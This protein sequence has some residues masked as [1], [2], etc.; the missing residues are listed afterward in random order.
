MNS[1][2]FREPAANELVAEKFRL[3]RL[4]GRGG[5]GSVW[6]GV[7]I[8]LGTR[9]AVK[10]IDSNYAENDEARQRF[11]NEARAAAKLN[12]KY[13]VKVFDHGVMADGRPYIV[14]EFLVGEPLDARIERLG[15]L[16]PA[17]TAV[18][19]SQVCRALSRAHSAGIVHRD[20]KPENIFLVRDD[21]DQADVAKVVDFG[22]AKF[23]DNGLGI[24]SST[25]TGSV[26][27]TPFYMSPEQGR[28][29]RNVDYRTDLWSL[30]VIAY[31]CI[32][33][34]LPFESESLGDLLVKI[35]TADLPIPSRV[36]AWCPPG[37]DA[38]FARVM[39]RDPAARFGSAQ[40]LAEQLMSVC[41]LAVARPPMSS[42]HE[43][44]Q[45]V[46]TPHAMNASGSSGALGGVVEGVT[47]PRVG[48]TDGAFSQTKLNA[49]RRRKTLFWG[50]GLGGALT[51]AGVSAL[52]LV[53]RNT[54][55]TSARG[56]DLR[57]TAPSGA[58]LV[59][60]VSVQQ[61]PA[62]ASSA[63][64]PSAA[65]SPE[66]APVVPPVEARREDTAAPAAGGRPVPATRAVV[67][68]NSGR[69]PSVVR[70]SAAPVP[71][72]PRRPA[73]RGSIDLGY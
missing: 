11:E 1:V 64:A 34:R 51:A 66:V 48:D 35:C 45:H 3:T 52:L 59:S 68:T 24:S 43:P 42:A 21:E 27:G 63:L 14:M 55:T 23:T 8:T 70:D 2:D 10:F 60:G 38:W 7:H 32:V 36:A 31:R 50:L 6:E 22:I 62:T 44:Y 49:G 73:G 65:T 56:E 15:H 53:G 4:I 17:E 13:A 72:A 33:G 61:Q 47:A 28:G 16:S 18:I 37:F 46:S 69:A 20:L 57:S 9:V 5:M 29:L 71:A 26:L 19:L 39:Q 67:R 41:G 54:D 40:E 12:S 30:G 25:R 58:A